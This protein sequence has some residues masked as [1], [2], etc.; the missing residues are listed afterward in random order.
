M[1]M[2]EEASEKF[3]KAVP[4]IKRFSQA[5]VINYEDNIHI[6]SIDQGDI[7]FRA[8]EIVAGS[9]CGL[10]ADAWSFGII[11]YQLLTGEFPFEQD[12]F[13]DG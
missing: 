9:T 1:S 6:D 11:L 7:R 5:E 12:K 10:K 8:P 4:R 2:V 3:E 13:E